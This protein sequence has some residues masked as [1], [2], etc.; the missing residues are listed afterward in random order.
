MIFLHPHP[1]LLYFY[2]LLI[3][4]CVLI[5][6]R[7]W[8]RAR[9]WMMTLVCG[10]LYLLTLL[11]HAVTRRV[12]GPE[13]AILLGGMVSPALYALL[14]VCF[15][16]V[17]G[18]RAPYG[19]RSSAYLGTKRIRSKWHQVLKSTFGGCVGGVTGSSLGVL[20]GILLFV[21]S[22]LVA[23]LMALD[24]NLSWQINQTVQR[25]VEWS[26]AL[27]GLLG[28]LAGGLAGWGCFNYR[29]VGDKLLIY[30]T[31]H[32]FLVASIV[33]RLFGK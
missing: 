25:L 7:H 13:L 31:I 10:S 9:G 1:A 19:H 11:T 22:P 17:R 12:T 3:I 28:M 30:L 14:Y 29:R 23:P 4:G 21:I 18:L 33:K 6:F 24:V 32:G 8:L 27:F 16:I 20:V 5:S 15:E 26:T 2:P